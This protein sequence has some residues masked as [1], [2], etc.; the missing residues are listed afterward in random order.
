MAAYVLVWSPWKRQEAMLRIYGLIYAP[1]DVLLIGDSILA[2]VGAPCPG[3][4]NLSVPGSTAADM[5]SSYHAA[6]ASR[7]PSKVVILIG[8]NDLRAGTPPAAVAHGVVG[9]AERLTAAVPTAEVVVLSVLPI[10]ENAVSAQATNAGVSELNLLLRAGLAKTRANFVDLTGL[11]G[12][13]ELEAGLTYDGLHLN[14][15]GIEVLQ[16]VLFGG[17]A[18]RANAICN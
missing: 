12:R 16:G 8:I 3:I 6:I 2:S 10:V 15:R 14:G 18:R 1:G 13:S 17:L 7:A 5:P 9:L 4:L 11:F